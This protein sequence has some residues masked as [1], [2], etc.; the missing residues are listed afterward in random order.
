MQ[1]NMVNDDAQNLPVIRQQWI[2][3][4]TVNGLSEQQ[5]KQHNA[6]VAAELF[7]LRTAYPTQARNFS[8]DEVAATNALWSEA[9]AGVE[10]GLLREAINR[11]IITNRKGFFPVIGQIVEVIEQIV[12]ERETKQKSMAVDDHSMWLRE[13]KRLINDGVNCSTCKF[14]DHRLCEPEYGDDEYERYTEARRIDA[15]NEDALKPYMVEKLYCQNPKS[16]KY[17][18]DYGWETDATILCDFYESALKN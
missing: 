5:R 9:F 10:I 15:W 18:D 3:A 1:Y 16:Y 17:E 6:F 11:F 7:K 2:A 13:R 12:A 4:Q 14:C 8:A